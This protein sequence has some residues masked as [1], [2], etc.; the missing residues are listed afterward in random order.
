MENSAVATEDQS[1]EEILQSIRRII[2]EEGDDATPQAAGSDILELTN[3]VSEDGSVVN[4]EAQEAPKEEINIDDIMFDAVP[5]AE[6]EPE[7]TE[8]VLKNIDD[9][10]GVTDK[11]TAP[12]PE[13]S[14]NFSSTPEPL[15]I[16]SLLSTE[17]AMAAS[18]AFKSL[19]RPQT[20]ILPAS[21]SLAFRSGTTVEDLML[22]SL[23]P[24]LKSW[25]D[26]NL[27]AMVERIVEREVKKLTQ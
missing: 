8:D 1:M 19:K 25:L 23:R 10:I 6:P 9:M 15:D 26:T 16:D 7:S 13:F 4:I 24:M 21:D 12:E 18:N 5:A 27:P 14:S 2:A 17:A 20:E 11:Q 22:E 3:V